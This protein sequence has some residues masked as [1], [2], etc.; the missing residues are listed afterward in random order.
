M[1][2][3]T[4]HQ[5][6][7]LLEKQAQGRCTEA[8]EELLT[9]WFEQTPVIDE[10]TFT[11]EE[12]KATIK[13]DILAAI[14]SEIAAPP[15]KERGNVRTIKWWTLS[16]AAAIILCLSLYGIF[17]L[18]GNT[19]LITVTVPKG[20]EKMPVTLPD[21]SLAWVS[22]GSRIS[23][24]KKFARSHRDVTLAGVAYF[25]VRPDKQSPFTVHTTKAVSVKVLG[26]SFVVDVKDEAEHVKI[27]VITGRVQIDEDKKRLDVLMPGESLSYSCLDNTFSKE[28][29]QPEEVNSWK[30]NSTIYLHA[31]SLQELAVLLHTMYRVDLVFNDQ[32]M[33]QYRFNMSFAKDLAIDDVLHILKTVSGLNFERNADQVKIT[34]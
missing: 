9:R 12:E 32:Q 3:L 22:G 16:A 11:S 24:P 26:T 28:R 7:L 6:F 15:S 23:Y 4:E 25:S 21:S 1:R 17:N 30:D 27:S 8:E 14:Q 29:Y 34:N 5:L 33:A 2:T 19:D 18:S 13:S 10:L 31:V 20:I